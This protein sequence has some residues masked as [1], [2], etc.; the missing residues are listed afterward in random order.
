MTFSFLLRSLRIPFSAWN[1]FSGAHFSSQLHPHFLTPGSN[2]RPTAERKAVHRRLRTLRGN[3]KVFSSLPPPK[4]HLQTRREVKGLCGIVWFKINGELLMNESI[5][6]VKGIH[7][8]KKKYRFLAGG[9]N[10]VFPWTLRGQW[11]SEV[12]TDPGQQTNAIHDYIHVP[13]AIIIS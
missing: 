11:H 13:C 3:I 7:G 2:S 12:E 8:V 10:L 6:Q 4:S 1:P 5:G 9:P